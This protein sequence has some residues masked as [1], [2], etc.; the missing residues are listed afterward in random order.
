MMSDPRDQIDQAIQ[1]AERRAFERGWRA[2]CAA[3]SALPTPS[4]HNE[5]SDAPAPTS[6]TQPPRRGRP[7]G[8]AID[9]VADCIASAPGMK[10]VEV[11]KAA[12]DIDAGIKE[13]TVRTC[14]RRL[15]LTKVIWQRSGLWYPKATKQETEK[16][17]FES[18]VGEAV[19]SPPH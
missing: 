12:Q 6:N 19:G 16:R 4:Y 2:A 7:S 1:E 17:V 15:K 5:A 18:E 11:V 9:I 8:K 10:G 3:A 14:L 13:R